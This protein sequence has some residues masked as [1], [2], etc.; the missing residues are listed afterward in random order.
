MHP[1]S[2]PDTDAQEEVH[3]VAHIA[4]GGADAEAG[5]DPAQRKGQGQA[6]LDHHHDARHDKRQD[7]QG[8]HDALIEVRGP[9]RRHEDPAHRQH[10][11]QGEQ[12]H[13]NSREHERQTRGGATAGG[14]DF[15]GTRKTVLQHLRRLV[16]GRKVH[17][18]QHV[19]R[20]RKEPVENEDDGA[21]EQ[22]VCQQ[23]PKR[24]FR[25]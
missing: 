12:H 13:P 21:E 19:F 10:E 17:I 14:H 20:K 7:Q 15:A 6:G 22:V 1:H 25:A 9:P 8:L 11:G 18:L 23:P 5:D 16:W 4:D 3:H 2:E 24:L